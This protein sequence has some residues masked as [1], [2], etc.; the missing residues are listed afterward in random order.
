[1]TLITKCENLLQLAF[2]PPY[3]RTVF[4]PLCAGFFFFI[5]Y[6]DI[7]EMA[8][9]F[10]GMCYYCSLLGQ[11]LLLNSWAKSPWKLLPA[12]PHP[13]FSPLCPPSGVEA[14]SPDVL[15]LFAASPRGGGRGSLVLD[16]ALR[17]C[18][19]P[20]LPALSRKSPYLLPGKRIHS[21]ID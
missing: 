5:L 1:M 15:A 20:A 8:M 10:N 16:F 12:S 14:P 13:H 4:K 19:F 9:F 21:R 11:E 2:L 6:F 3:N 7:P 17:L 18:L